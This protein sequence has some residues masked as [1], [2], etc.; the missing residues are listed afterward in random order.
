MSLFGRCGFSFS[1][2]PSKAL[3]ASIRQPVATTCILSTC[4][5]VTMMLAFRMRSP[6][7]LSIISAVACSSAAADWT[8]S[9]FVLIGNPSYMHVNKFGSVRM[10]SP[11]HAPSLS[12]QNLQKNVKICKKIYVL[13][14]LFID[15]MKFD[16]MY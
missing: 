7:R 4:C 5:L 16:R 8:A 15:R 6:T 11:A 12:L 13:H 2:R 3:E 9:F 10:A 1:A 14:K